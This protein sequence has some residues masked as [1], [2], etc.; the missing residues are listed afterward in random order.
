[1]LCRY[2][3]VVSCRVVSCRV[4]SC[5]VVSCR[6]VSCRLEEEPTAKPAADEPSGAGAEAATGQ[7]NAEEKEK[8]E[9]LHPKATGKAPG[10]PKGKK[11]AA[12]PPGQMACQKKSKY[13]P[14]PRAPCPAIL[15]TFHVRCRGPSEGRLRAFR[16][17]AS[18][19]PPPPPH[20]PTRTFDSRACGSLKATFGLIWFTL[21]G[22][23]IYEQ[24][25]A[26]SN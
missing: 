21:Q 26:G 22:R 12:Q 23:T 14:V 6:V 9:K 18:P 4:V 13:A 15:S 16:N 17:G 19:C 7:P 24:G 8:G 2:V 5:R 11:A 25:T 1:M 10:A 20:P 3:R